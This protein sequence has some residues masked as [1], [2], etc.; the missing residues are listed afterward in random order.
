LAGAKGLTYGVPLDLKEEDILDSLQTQV[1]T[2][3]G[4]DYGHA[5]ADTI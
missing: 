4:S 5:W 1:Q 2:I 3:R